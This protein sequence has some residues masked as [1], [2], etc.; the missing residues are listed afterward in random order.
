MKSNLDKVNEKISPLVSV[1]IPVYNTQDFIQICIESVLNQTY[2]NFE[3]ICIDDGSTDKSADIIQ[4]MMLEDERISLIIIENHGQGY[5]R[6]MAVNLCKGDYI[7]F[8]DSDDYL[9]PLAL[10][11]CIKRME[12]DHSDFV[13]F[14][15][16]TYNIFEKKVYSMQHPVFQKYILFE[17]ECL[18]LLSL[19]PI[20][21][22]NKLFKKDFIQLHSIRFGEGYIYEDTP[23]WV[24]AVLK[25]KCVSLIHS[26]LYRVTINMSSST[27]VNRQTNWHSESFIKAL[28]ETWKI[29]EECE[30]ITPHG[31][32]LYFSLFQ[33]F[34]DYYKTRCPRNNKKVFLREFV[35]LYACAP[36]SDPHTSR[37]YTFLLRNKVFEKKKHFILRMCIFYIN[38]LKPKV[39]KIGKKVSAH[40]KKIMS[41]RPLKRFFN[42][43]SVSLKNE[44][45]VNLGRSL[46]NDVVLFLGF[47]YRYT[48]NSRYLF[49]EILYKN[50]G[51]KKLF[52]ITKDPLVPCQY[53]IEPYTE[54]YYRFLARSRVII[55][56]SWTPQWLQKRSGTTWLQLWHGTPIKK[57]LFDSHE[58]F[59]TMNNPGNKN[60]KYDDIQKWDYLLADSIGA[61]AIFQRCFLFPQDRILTTRYPRVRYLMNHKDDADYRRKLKVLYKL[62][63]GKKVVL[64]LPTWRD[65]NY[66]KPEKEFDSSY[67]LNLQK[68][69]L[70]LGETYDTLY[71]DHAFLSAPVNQ[72]IRML[73]DAETQELLLIADYLITDYSS[74]LFDALTIGLP[75]LMYCNDIE[76][77]EDAR[78]NYPEVFQSLFCLCCKNE[79]EIADKITSG[80]VPSLP[81]DFIRKYTSQTDKPILEQKLM[82]L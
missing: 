55:F 40:L 24:K 25:A 64:Y 61:G 69:Q 7:A 80:F 5:A 74:V 19:F 36:L 22:V 47:D 17:N 35:D 38:I 13:V 2:K 37:L 50:N 79:E 30:D 33:K 43:R 8:L 82:G 67:L 28:K 3:I 12:Q 48:G 66:K 56:E 20:F 39:L 1:I 54:R 65:Y 75:V 34:L 26:P 52:F 70:L 58:K 71:K 16:Y 76:K 49:E 78:G 21:T 72:N 31:S 44:Y 23:F 60:R 11:L 77:N 32:S 51:Q 62:D 6:N 59:I 4:R 10:E 14:D 57:L 45:Y 41:L 73:P 29:I 18:E 68:L 42:N 81:A 53:R 15:W 46:Y 63:T 27:K 9:E